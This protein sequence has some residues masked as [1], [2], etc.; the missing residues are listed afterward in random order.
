M[1][2]ITFDLRIG[3]ASTPEVLYGD[4]L[5]QPT[6]MHT[7]GDLLVLPAPS[8]VTIIDG[9]GVAEDVLESPTGDNPSWGYKVTIVRNGGGAWTEYVAVPSGAGDVA[10]TSLER[11]VPPGGTLSLQSASALVAEAAASAQDSED[12]RIAAEAAAGLVG[13][14]AGA[15]VVAAVGPGGAAEGTLGSIFKLAA[16]PNGVDDT[17]TIVDAMATGKRLRDGLYK[18]LGTGEDRGS[19][20]LVGMGYY[21]TKVTIPAGVYL[22]DSNRLWAQ[23]EVS[24]IEFEGGAGTLRNRY[25]S[26]NVTNFFKVTGC[27]FRLYTGAAIS[28]NSPDMPYWKIEDSIFWGANSSTSIGIALNGLTDGNSIRNNKFLLNKVHVKL[29]YGG[30]NAYLENNDFIQFASGT[31]RAAVWVVPRTTNSNA[32]AGFVLERC[33]FGNEFMDSTDYRVL[34]A[35]EGSGTYF[36]DKLPNLGADSTGFI[37]GHTIKDI[38]VNGGGSSN[39][40]IVYSTTPN[41]RACSYGPVIING[42]NPRYM[43]EFRTPPTTSVPE[44]QT[45]TIGPIIGE[46]TDS[47]LNLSNAVGYFSVI[48][49]TQKFGASVGAPLTHMGGAR[50]TAF[51]K[52][53]NPRIN[54]FTGS[55]GSVTKTQVT[56]AV[57]GTDAAEFVL[58]TGTGSTYGYVISGSVRAGVPIWIEFDVKQGSTDPVDSLN[59]LFGLDTANPGAP[60][61]FYRRRIRPGTGFVTYRCLTYSQVASNSLLL[62]FQRASGGTGT[63]V[64][65]GRVR[66]YHAYEPMP[67]DLVLPDITTSTTAP[68]AGAGAALPATPAG[69]AT[70]YINGVERK[71]AYY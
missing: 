9:Q 12:S 65:I 30:N 22:I 10:Y 23:I 7:S 31:G 35:D 45:S 49:P 42:T 59:V 61:N 29:G 46:G 55:S 56:D 3:G 44:V 17:A 26:S 24:G 43:V 37:V 48:D 34:Y 19:A 52:L 25:T 14:P 54:S 6:A 2:N 57:G 13:A 8:P 69:Y 63:T 70:I 27:K 11:L 71:I 39:Q 40:A 33:K 1:P 4:V 67:T 47:S 64:V 20:T 53:L 32:G 36:G 16:P 15:A 38:L 58:G 41:V 68:S 5:I 21:L 60:S 51:T 66:M 28:H 50:G 18:Y 62:K